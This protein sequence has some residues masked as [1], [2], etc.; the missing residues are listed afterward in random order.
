MASVRTHAKLRPRWRNRKHADSW[1]QTLERHAFP[2]LGD[3]D[4][5]RITRADV[6]AVLTPM[7]GTRPETA[8]R[9]RQWIRAV[10]RWSW[11]HGHVTENVAGEAIDGALP[12]MPAVKSH[13]RALPYREVAAALRTVEASKASLTVK[14][15]FRFVVLTATRSGEARLATWSEIDVVS[16]ERRVPPSRMKAQVEHRVT[17]LIRHWPCGSESGPYV[18]KPIWSSCHRHARINLCPTW[19]SQW[20]CETAASQTERPSTDFETVFGI[21]RQNRRTRHTRSWNWL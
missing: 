12:A 4:G 2:I 1:L 14:A 15:C 21:G 19:H 6:L 13:L 9:V 8:R 7:W 16:K 3:L 18:V 5:D 10:L 11:A 20:R 17:C